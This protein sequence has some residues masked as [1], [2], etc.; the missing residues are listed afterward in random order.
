MQ[1]IEERF[2]SKVD[3]KGQT[4]C[5]LWIASID[6]IGYGLFRVK[7]L[8]KA[9]RVAFALFYDVDLE[10]L[11]NLKLLHICNKQRNCV[12]PE[13]L[14][15]GT[16]RDNVIDSSTN[17][18]KPIMTEDTKQKV[19]EE[20]ATGLYTQQDIGSRYGYSQVF[21]SKVLRHHA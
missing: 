4:D 17:R 13:H 8:Y 15:I 20:Y 21:V 16:Q 10:I 1:N 6:S 9:H 3:I 18:P 5:W 11:E 2:W 14:Y 7:K 12:N 19:R